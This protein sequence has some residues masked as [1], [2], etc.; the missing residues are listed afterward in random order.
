LSIST[1][2]ETI[3]AILANAGEASSRADDSS[4]NIQ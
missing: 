4:P 3:N 1:L 2:G